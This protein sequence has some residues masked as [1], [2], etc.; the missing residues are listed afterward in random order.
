MPTPPSVNPFDEPTTCLTVNQEWASHLLGLMWQGEKEYY[1]DADVQDGVD[2]IRSIAD[3]LVV[4]NCPVSDYQV[5]Y[6]QTA[7]AGGE[8]SI[9]F[10]DIPQDFAI[11]KIF[12]RLRSNVAAIVQQLRVII[13][14]NTTASNYRSYGR[15]ETGGPTTAE[16]ARDG[17]VGGFEV[18]HGVAGNTAPSGEF[19]Q[20]ELTFYNYT[21]AAY[22]KTFVANGVVRV[23]TG[24]TGVRLLSSGGSYTNTGAAITKITLAPDTASALASGSTYMAVGIGAL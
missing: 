18:Y 6:P 14:D 5:L 19:S 11:F 2:G 4:G 16:Q 17:T 15:G 24:T 23:L 8:G 21:V 1:W 9:I 22:V 20:L 10:A 12:A 7:L 3:A 13:N